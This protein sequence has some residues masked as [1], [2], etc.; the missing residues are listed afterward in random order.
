MSTTPASLDLL[1]A[2]VIGPVLTVLTVAVLGSALT[3]QGLNSDGYRSLELSSKQPPSW[4][5]GVAWTVIYTTYAAVW[6]TYVKTAAGHALFATNMALNLLWV[7]LFFG[8]KTFTEQT[9][10][11]SRIVILALLAL[12]VGQAAYMWTSPK[13]TGN[14]LPT[15]IL[16]VY[17]SWLVVATGLNFGAKLPASPQT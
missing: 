15:F 10:N 5:F 9:L 16:L 7:W 11:A 17:A 14:A 3:S 12:T 2:Q 6:A 13:I 4:A 8:S 1:S